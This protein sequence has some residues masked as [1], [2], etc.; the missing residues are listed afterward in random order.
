MGGEKKIIM[1]V[2]HLIDM[3]ISKE[4]KLDS[5]NHPLLARIKALD[6]SNRAPSS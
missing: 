1:C 2:G 3:L 5:Q 4:V 6:D